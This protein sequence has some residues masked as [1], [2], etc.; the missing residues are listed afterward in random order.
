MQQSF[1]DVDH[2]AATAYETLGKC[3]TDEKKI[4]G[5]ATFVD[6]QK[7]VGWIKRLTKGMQ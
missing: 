4:R 6:C 7:I 3:A 2:W 1:E 5:L